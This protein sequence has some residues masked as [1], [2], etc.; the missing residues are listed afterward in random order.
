M[1]DNDRKDL[2]FYRYNHWDDAEYIRSLWDN[3]P[4]PE[5]CFFPSD[6]IPQRS[7]DRYFDFIIDLS[8]E[9]ESS[10]REIL[11]L[12]VEFKQREKLMRFLFFVCDMLEFTW[13][14]GEDSLGACNFQVDFSDG[15]SVLYSTNWC[16]CVV[17]VDGVQQSFHDISPIAID[18]LRQLLSE[19][20]GRM[21]TYSIWEITNE[22]DRTVTYRRMFSK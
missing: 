1:N 4:L 21:R 15:V 9:A 2:P 6:F 14:K 22:N 3:A 10:L 18:E 17:L 7:P 16:G 11:G 20:L 19:I 8:L 5:G 12:L 13:N